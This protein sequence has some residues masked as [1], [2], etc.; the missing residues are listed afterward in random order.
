[1][2]VCLRSLQV[3]GVRSATAVCHDRALALQAHMNAKHDLDVK[4]VSNA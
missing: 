4:K 3:R 2:G 1:M